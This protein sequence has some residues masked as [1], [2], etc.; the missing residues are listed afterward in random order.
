MRRTT[1]TL[2]LIL[3]TLAGQA[4]PSEPVAG[5]AGLDR[6]FDE[7]VSPFLRANCLACHG[8][9]KPG[10]DLNLGR[11]ATLESVVADLDQWAVVA[12]QVE[13]E[14][15]PPAKAKARPTAEQRGELVAWIRDLRKQRG[16]PPGRRPRPRPRASAE[17]RGIRLHDPRPHRRRPPPHPGL[18]RRPRQRGRLRQHG[19]IPDDVA[20]PGQEIPR[21]RPTRWPITWSSSPDGLAFAADPAVA[22]TDR[23]KYCVRRIIDF[24]KK[25][26]VDLADYF[27]AA[28]RFRAPGRPRQAGR[29]RSTPSPPRPA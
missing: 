27:L 1:A 14:T 5:P 18:P 2:A 6:R 8:E 24:Y 10:G 29:D 17:Q 12:E 4:S 11:Y 23:D 16:D 7:S 13:A 21:S 22:D 9:S 26:K 19:R 28:W 15:M 25:Q 3:A 20:R